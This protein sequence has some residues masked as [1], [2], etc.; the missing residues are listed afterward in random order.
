MVVIKGEGLTFDDVLI[1][2]KLSNINSRK[3]ID[4][5]SYLTRKIKLNIPIVS[6]PMDTVTE[7]R[8]AIAMARE[9]AVGVIHRF[10]PIEEQVD[11]VI[12]VKRSEGT[13]IEKP[14]TISPNAT[15]GDM[16][17]MSKFY[18]VSSFLVADENNHLLGIVT[19][20]DIIFEN[21]SKKISEVM[22]PV[23]KLITAKP[24]ISIEEAKEVLKSHK[25]EKLPIVD[26]KNVIIGLI[27]MKDIVNLEKYPKASKDKKGRLMVGAAV[28]VKEDYMKRVEKLIEAEVDFIVIDVANG[29]TEN[30]RKVVKEIKREFDIDVIAGNVATAE[31]TEALISA[32]A[33]CIRVGIGPGSACTTRL[34][35]G[36]GVP[37]L[38]AIMECA[39][40]ASR[41][42]I[43]IMADGGIRR[44]GDI[45]KALAAGASTVMIGN[46]LAGTEES[47]GVAIMRK[48]R[49]YKIFR[50]MAS[51]AAYLSKREKEG[52]F[53]EEEIEAYVSEGTEGLVEYK[54]TVS[55]VI[56]QLIG[57]LRSGM[58]YVGARN[59][60]ELKKNAVFIKVTEAGIRES[61][62]HDLKII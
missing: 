19:F 41:F 1:V 47:P 16:I 27:T 33:D 26:E 3:E 40:V 34:V 48:G 32:G 29:Y 58:S 9:G 36:V 44:P 8:L 2:P 21:S 14:Y 15:V 46:L 54:G 23:Q 37:Q 38:T 6:S 28:G 45:V 30:V 22:T 61:G 17:E 39:E 62:V 52:K 24:G 42:D 4:V 51:H 5:S 18:R 43:P 59:I 55:E 60:E 20:R 56:H 12:K 53:D 50:G 57:G 10:M 13:I 25:I 49:K 31:G 11:Q 35:A 7:A